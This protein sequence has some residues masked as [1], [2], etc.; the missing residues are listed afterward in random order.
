MLALTA[1][2]LTGPAL[3]NTAP[4]PTWHA[5]CLTTTTG[6][7]APD[8]NC[9]SLIGTYPPNG[10]RPTWWYTTDTPPPVGTR[11]RTGTPRAPRTGHITPA[12]QET[13]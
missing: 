4:G 13:P 7:R 8:R 2:A 12:R 3:A 10:K 6:T 1:T 11:P 9:P 5:I